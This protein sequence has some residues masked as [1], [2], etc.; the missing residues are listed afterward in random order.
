M[1]RWKLITVAVL[2]ALPVLLF[3]GFGAWAL[4][5]SGHW[6]WLWWTLPVCWGI[7][8]FLARRWSSDLKIPMPEIDCSQWTPQ[9]QEATK[10][11]AAEQARVGEVPAQQLTNP[12]F[13]TEL[14]QNLALKIA[15]HYHP[16][17]KD[18]LGERSVVEILAATQLIS[19]DVEDWFLKY[20]PASHLVT[21]AQWRMLSHAPTWWQTASN[22]GWVAS[23][24]MNPLNIARYVVSKV[25]MEPFTKQLQQNLLG[26]FYSLYVRQAGYYLIELNSGRLRAGSKRYRELM[27]KLHGDE[28]PKAAVPAP[29]PVEPPPATTITVAV[30]GQVKAGKSSLVNCV[31][32]SQ[33][34]VMDV[35]PSTMDVKRYTL[36]WPDRS[37]EVVLLD[38][39]GYSDAGAT[40]AQLRETQEAVRAADLM[41]LVLDARSPARDA[42]VKMLSSLEAWFSAQP[43]LKPP[44]IV[45]VLNQ[46]DGLSPV[47]EW[48]PPYKWRWPSSPKERNIGAAVE[49]AREV[50]GA[51]VAA[52]VPTCADIEHQRSWNIEE[53]LLPTMSMHLDAARAA[54][55]LRGL[56]TE[57][58]RGKVQQVVGQ[59]LEAGKRIFDSIDGLR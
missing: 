29:S 19:E 50:F 24:A 48:S 26:A 23:I 11:I 36:R 42:D 16:K 1:P 51:R 3:A 33:Q 4:Y 18:P 7:G 8:G 44:R 37:D 57:Y 6:A 5:R 14:T 49:Y 12:Q 15:Q 10:I 59:V 32:G 45:V 43:R 39:P 41:L 47:M 31:L 17:S 20:V 58:D 28:L 2:S 30:V 38:T 56:H 25:A 35:L 52:F 54:A 46:V 9:D 27:R 53:E 34:A 22:A 21:V 13:Y 55:L 40:G